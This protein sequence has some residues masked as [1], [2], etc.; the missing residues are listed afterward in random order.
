MQYQLKEYV[1][2]F[3]DIL[4]SS[5]KIQTDCEGSLNIIHTVYDNALITCEQLYDN[6]IISPLKP[7][8]KIYSDNIVIAVPTDKNGTYGA[9][10]S[11]VVF[12]GLIQREFLKHKYLIRGGIAV[13][14]FFVDQTMIWG[15][16]HLNAY[17]IESNVAIYPRI[18]IHPDTVVKLELAVNQSRQKWIKQD[19]DGLFFIDYMNKLAFANQSDYLSTILYRINEG[20][21][22][23]LK[24]DD[25]VKTQQKLHWHNTYLFSVLEQYAPD[26]IASLREELKI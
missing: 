6:E 18:V 26:K 4:G 5:K 2:A 9:F 23:F 17:Y 12:C 11:V 7:I 10:Y 20:A 21:G 13:G 3:V 8:V 19:T 25:D 24:A 16:A 14:D 1:V 15:N 22:L